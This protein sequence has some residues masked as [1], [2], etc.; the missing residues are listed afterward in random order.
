MRALFLL[1]LAF[2]ASPAIPNDAASEGARLL[3]ESRAKY[4]AL[5][6]YS[7]SVTVVTENRFAGSPPVVERHRIQTRYRAPRLYFFQFDEDPKA[8]AE[9]LVIWC[10]GGDFNSWWSTTRVH[11]VYSEGRGAAAFALSSPTT[12]GATLL[13]PTWIFPQ[14]KMT[15]PLT[16]LVN[17][18]LEGTD[19]VVGRKAYRIAADSDTS[20]S[21]GR[22]AQ[23]RPITIWL[24]AETLLVLKIIL[25]TPRGSASGALVRETF[26]LVPSVN[27]QMENAAFRFAVPGE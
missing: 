17:V 8:G 23:S 26:E 24:D 3:E 6:S 20:Y 25:D 22:G 13:L 12:R 10:D 27:P 11:D 9:R 18:R 7:D 4:A 14:A 19:T 21:N 5:R 15:G 16:S 1:S 2:V